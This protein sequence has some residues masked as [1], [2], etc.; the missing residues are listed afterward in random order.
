MI[1]N[2]RTTRTASRPAW[3][4]VCCCVLGLLIF[5]SQAHALEISSQQVRVSYQTVA[6]LQRFERAITPWNDISDIDLQTRLDRDVASV[7]ETFGLPAGPQIHLVLLPD[8][9]TVNG[10]YQVEYKRRPDYIA[11]FSPKSD[12]IYLSLADV[13]RQVLIHE[14]THAVM[15]HYFK[16]PMPSKMH[17][18]LAQLAEEAAR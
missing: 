18:M 11:Y 4:C 6:D 14:L 10:L 16:Q 7:L 5:A 8:A 13:D 3:A 15:H 9:A 2:T 12:A 1:S 17:E